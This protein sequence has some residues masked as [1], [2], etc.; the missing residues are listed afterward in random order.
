MDENLA[1]ILTKATG[2][3]LVG[4]NPENNEEIRLN[5]LKRFRGGKNG[6]HFGH[7]V[8]AQKTKF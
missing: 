1:L 3:S 5:P 2:L 8:P 4:G 6:S 7:G